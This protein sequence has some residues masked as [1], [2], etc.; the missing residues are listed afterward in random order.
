M[1]VKDKDYHGE[2][3]VASHT[4]S[5]GA[6]SMNKM[7]HQIKWSFLIKTTERFTPS[8]HNLLVSIFSLSEQIK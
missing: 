8:Y 6:T 2:N 7:H 5:F 1:K 3:K 4:Y